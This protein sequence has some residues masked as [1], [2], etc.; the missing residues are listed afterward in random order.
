MTPERKDYL[1][2]SR[3][4]ER[5]LEQQQ[6]NRANMIDGVAEIEKAYAN[7]R[8]TSARQLPVPERTKTGKRAKIPKGKMRLG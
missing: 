3:H 5:L 7:M 6:V 8:V 2:R 1:E 4:E